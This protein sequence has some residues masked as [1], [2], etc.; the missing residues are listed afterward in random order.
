M[1]KLV[2]IRKHE[3]LVDFKMKKKVYANLFHTKF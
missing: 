2:E 1:K 3:N